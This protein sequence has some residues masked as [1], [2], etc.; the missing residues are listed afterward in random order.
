M[1]L[2]YFSGSEF[3][4]VRQLT[5]LAV[6]GYEAVGILR[7]ILFYRVEKHPVFNRGALE[8]MK[9]VSCVYDLCPLFAR[10]F[11]RKTGNDRAHGGMAM[12]GVIAVAVNNLFE[13]SVR[14]YV[15]RT[16]RPTL[17]RDFKSLVYCG[18]IE[19][20]LVCGIILERGVNLDSASLQFT[21]KRHMKLPYMT[22]HRGDEQNFHRLFSIRFTAAY[23]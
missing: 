18:Q 17:K 19:S 11:G 21:D 14:L 2:I 10:A 4:L 9:A 6:Y 16:Q 8:K 15:I 22:A 3:F 13:L 7:Q 1:N 20:R 5:V 23:C 12:H